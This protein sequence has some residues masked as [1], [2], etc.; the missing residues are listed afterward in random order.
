MNE[1]S[2]TNSDVAR[3]SELLQRMDAA[4]TRFHTLAAEVEAAGDI[5]KFRMGRP[6]QFL[7][8]L[9]VDM[10]ARSIDMPAA[11]TDERRRL[12]HDLR[13]LEGEIA[14][15]E[16]KLAAARAEENAYLRPG[17]QAELRAMRADVSALRSELHPSERVMRRTRRRGSSG[18]DRRRGA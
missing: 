10:S 15:A 5:V 1:A 4:H 14:I 18:S 17:P 12:E 9:L 7:M 11:H 2:T 16:A 3:R 13:S 6:L 8:E